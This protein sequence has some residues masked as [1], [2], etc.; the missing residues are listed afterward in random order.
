MGSGSFNSDR[1]YNDAK[2][3]S[4]HGID[5]F[6]YSKTHSTVHDSLDPRRINKKPLKKL[7]SRDS[8]EHPESNAVLLSFDVT[9]S[10]YQ[11]AVQAQ[12]A[13]PALMDLLPKYLPHPQVAMA[14]N[15]DLN[16]TSVDSGALQVSDFESDNRIDEHIRSIRLVRAGGSN[17]GESYDLVLYTAA[18]K[19]VLDCLEKRGKKGYLFLYADEP[20]FTE[21]K[22]SHVEKA[23]GDDIGEDIPIESIIAEARQQYE[24]FVLWPVG[25]YAHAHD[26][27]LS[28]FGEEYVITLQHPERICEVVAATIGIAESRID[29]ETAVK[30]LIAVGQNVNAANDLVRSLVPL[31]NSRAVAHV[32]SGNLTT[33]GKG[34]SRL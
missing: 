30:D 20:F 31:A 29:T 9:G 15:D 27:Y 10:N 34:A 22:A 3:R 24:T 25:G 32:S 23:F 26:Q 12:K 33:S 13:L 11:R 16:C 4:S 5:D 19:T 7:E 2:T 8:A 6:D 18:R 17:D 21:V 14:A 28:L 1:Y